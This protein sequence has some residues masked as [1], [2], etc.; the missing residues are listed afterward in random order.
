MLKGTFMLSRDMEKNQMQV[1]KPIC[2]AYRILIKQYF[3]SSKTM[4]NKQI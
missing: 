1:K 4:R 3:I 2:N